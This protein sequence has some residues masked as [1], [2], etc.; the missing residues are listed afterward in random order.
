[1][2]PRAT[3]T[4]GLGFALIAAT[5]LLHASPGRAAP[6][7]RTSVSSAFAVAVRFASAS[8]THTHVPA[9]AATSSPPIENV[10]LPVAT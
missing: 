6:I 2:R 7:A 10:A 4:T 5:L 1:M 8:V 3:I 9:G